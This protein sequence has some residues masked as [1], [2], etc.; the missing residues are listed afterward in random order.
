MVRVLGPVPGREKMVEKKR[1]KI[2]I[3]KLPEIVRDEQVS[4][5]TE[6]IPAN[7]DVFALMDKRDETQIVETLQGRYLQE[8]VYSFQQEGHLVTQLSWLGIQ[9][10]SRAFGGLKCDVEKETETEET[11]RIVIRATDTRTNAS[12][13]GVAQQ[14]KKMMTKLGVMDDK[15]AWQKAYSKAQRNALRQLLPQTLLK[16]WIDKKLGKKV[17]VPPQPISTET[18]SFGDKITIPQQR[19]LFAILNKAGINQEDLRAYLLRE[20]KI[21]STMAIKKVDYE[22]IIEWIQQGGDK[23]ETQN[24]QS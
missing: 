17:E 10:A 2:K 14:E 19:R 20:Y 11:I 9:E 7:V 5:A 13:F 12:R 3:P 22:K 24:S 6:I 1:K 23:S 15:F 8:F 18:P 4:E 16:E 21:K